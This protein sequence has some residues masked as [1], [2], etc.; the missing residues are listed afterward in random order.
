MK[1]SELDLK[2]RTAMMS[3]GWGFGGF[4]TIETEKVGSHSIHWNVRFW[5]EGWGAKMSKDQSEA[6]DKRNETTLKQL[7]GWREKMAT[8]K[9]DL[10]K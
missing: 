1:Y 3:P 6:R 2:N 8:S 9:K 4:Q 5:K 10:G 7:G